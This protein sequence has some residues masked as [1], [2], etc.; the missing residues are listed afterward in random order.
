MFIKIVICILFTLQSVSAEGYFCPYT[1]LGATD[2]NF[3]IYDYYDIAGGGAYYTRQG[4]VGFMSMTEY[5]R[6]KGDLTIHSDAGEWKCNDSHGLCTYN[7]TSCIVN[8]D[9]APDCKALCQ[10]VLNGEGPDCLGNCPNGSQSNTLYNQYC[11]P[12]Y[13][14]SSVTTSTT[15]P[16]STSTVTSSATSTTTLTSTASRDIVISETTT[17]IVTTTSVITSTPTSTTTVRMCTLP[18][19]IIKTYTVVRAA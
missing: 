11:Q 13:Y 15:T 1:D 7:N 12:S 8:S 18:T 19:P 2:T 3:L 10:A 5:C 6:A 9:R 16:P 17:S 4:E 14:S